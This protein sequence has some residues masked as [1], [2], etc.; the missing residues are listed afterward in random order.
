MLQYI[1]QR[2]LLLIPTFL[3][4]TFLAYAIMLAAPGDP[5]DLFFAGGAGAGSDGVN[6][7]N[8][9]EIKAAKEELRKELGL[10][11]AI[12]IQYALWL[13]RM[14]RGELGV[15]FKDRLPVWDK[16]VPRLPVTLTLNLVSIFLTYLIALPLGI[17][18][19]VR[20][21][22]HHSFRIRPIPG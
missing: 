6:V 5:V 14:L 10:D 4:V 22:T 20:N 12:P 2:V 9:S 7:D 11:R 16:I 8:L 3:G 15:S 13:G 1:I 18:S 21:G 19:A 17:Y